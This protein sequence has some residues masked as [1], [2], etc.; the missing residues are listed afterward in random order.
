MT[1]FAFSD[2]KWPPLPPLG[3]SHAVFIA[4]FERRR[5]IYTQ[6]EKAIVKQWGGT[7]EGAKVL[8]KI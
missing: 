3:R 5:F 8:N 6:G 7:E 1:A 2:G 4:I